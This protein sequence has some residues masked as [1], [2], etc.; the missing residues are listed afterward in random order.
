MNR[1]LNGKIYIV[2]VD[3]FSVEE[4]HEAA[5]GARLVAGYLFPKDLVRMPD[6]A[7]ALV[8]A[9]DYLMLDGPRGRAKFL[10]EFEALAGD[11]PVAAY[12]FD[13]DGGPPYFEG[14]VAF[15]R[16][17]SPALIR[18]ALGLDEGRAAA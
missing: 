4:A 10:E 7:L 17:L 8:A 14:G 15:A 2:T 11:I 9:M 5:A 6:D 18:L 13:F 1:I 12:G 3:Y 16:R